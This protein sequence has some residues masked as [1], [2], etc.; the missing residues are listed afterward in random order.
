[1]HKRRFEELHGVTLVQSVSLASL[2][3]Q[4]VNL[5]KHLNVVC[6]CVCVC[7]CVYTFIL[8]PGW[9]TGNV[10]LSLIPREKLPLEKWCACVCV[11]VGRGCR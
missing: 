8:I 3:P 6:V 4:E 11:C 2:C 1:M 7:V 5:K 9:V 10:S